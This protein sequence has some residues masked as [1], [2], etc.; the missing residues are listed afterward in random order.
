VR[1]VGLFVPPSDVF[2]VIETRPRLLRLLTAMDGHFSHILWLAL[3]ADHYW[4]E[5]ERVED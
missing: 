4:I 5:F 1:G 2:G 3:F